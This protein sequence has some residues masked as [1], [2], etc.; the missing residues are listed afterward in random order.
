MN[1]QQNPIPTAVSCLH[2]RLVRD[3][4]DTVTLQ[5]RLWPSTPAP[6]TL[7][8]VWKQ[9]LIRARLPVMVGTQFSHEQAV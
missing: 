4:E 1:E 2:W 8:A 6:I 9:A 5:S 7:S 3:R